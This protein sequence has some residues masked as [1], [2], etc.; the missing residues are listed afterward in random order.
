LTQIN[1]IENTR[2][3]PNKTSSYAWKKREE[4][5]STTQSIPSATEIAKS[6]STKFNKRKVKNQSTT[7]SHSQKTPKLSSLALPQI[8]IDNYPQEKSWLTTSNLNINYNSQDD[9]QLDISNDR[10]EI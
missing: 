1:F 7:L 9:T 8:N 3:S 4:K 2:S 6:L 5:E 10:N